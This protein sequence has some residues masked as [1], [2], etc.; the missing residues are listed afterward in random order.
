MFLLF[1]RAIVKKR[2]ELEYKL[3]KRTKN[4]GDYLNYIQYEIT[5]LSLLRVRRK[6][7]YY[8]PEAHNFY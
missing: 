8:N 6:V 1:F 3:Q 7:G 2:R 4:K 5:L